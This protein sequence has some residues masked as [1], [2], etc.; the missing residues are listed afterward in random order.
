MILSVS[1]RTDIPAVYADWFFNRV[2]DEKVLVP[3][4]MN[5]RAISNVSLSPDVVD[6]IVF[7]TKNPIP[8][9]NR[10]SELEKYKGRFYFTYTLNPYD[11]DAEPNIPSKEKE[12]IPAFIELSKA[13]GKERVCWRFD[14]IFISEKYSVGYHLSKFEEYA[15]QISPYTEKC[16]VSFVDLYDKT[17]RNTKNLGLRAPTIEEEKFL[18]SEMVKVTNKFGIILDT[19]CELHNYDFLGVRH[20][21]CIDKDRLERIGGYHL[22]VQKDKTQRPACGCFSSIDIGS[23]NT[24]TNACLYCYANFNQAEVKKNK[25]EHDPNSPLLFGNITSEMKIT[26]RKME[27]LIEVPKEQPYEEQQGTLF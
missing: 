23:Y 1:R 22:N 9:F 3:N 2:K 26:N 18:L 5:P 12:L 7:W 10:L 16:T 4:P 21:H 13:L 25:A 17:L 6:G 8:M 24:C 20:A 15:I 11:K 14:P 27:S 19:C